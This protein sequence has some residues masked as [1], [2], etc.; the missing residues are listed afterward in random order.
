MALRPAVRYFG[1]RR[2]A[3]LCREDIEE[4]KRHQ[5]TAGRTCGG[6]AGTGLRPVTVKANLDRLSSV[7][8]LAVLDGKVAQNPCQ[9]VKRPR[10]TGREHTTWDPADVQQFLATAARDRLHACWLLSLL[11]LRRGEVTGLRWRDVSMAGGT[12]T[13]ARTRTTVGGKVVEKGPKSRRSART[14]PLFEPLTS[15][16]AALYARQCAERDALGAAYHGTVDDGWVCAEEDGQPWHPDRYSEWFALLRSQAGVPKIR[17][18]DCR[19][20]MN[21]HLERLGVP[22]TIRAAWLGHTILENRGSYLAPAQ[23]ADLEPLAGELGR[24]LGEAM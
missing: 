22:D 13:I 8:D 1:Q 6:E 3:D 24:F 15:A 9:R 11:G 21:S 12:V 23:L 4:Y 14:L 7:F 2:A 19:A 16:L 5:L 20:T 18:H 10:V 17:L